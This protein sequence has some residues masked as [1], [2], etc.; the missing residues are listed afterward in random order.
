MYDQYGKEQANAILGTVMTKIF[1]PGLD[2]VTAEY[3]SKQLGDTTIFS[4]TYQDFPGKKNDNIRYAEQKRALMHAGEVRQIGA[5]Q[6]LLIINDTA[7]PIKAAYPP[8]AVLKQKFISPSYGTPK[9]IYLGDIDAG[10]KFDDNGDAD[11]S[12]QNSPSTIKENSIPNRTNLD[13]KINER[14][15]EEVI[16]EIFNEN[17][18]LTETEQTNME[19]Q[20]E[21]MTDQ[22]D[23]ASRMRMAEIEET[24][25]QSE[26]SDL[27]LTI[28]IETPPESVDESDAL[29]SL[30]DDV[31]SAFRELDARAEIEITRSV[32]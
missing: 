1:L 20:T 7:P 5:H 29:D 6:E 32:F 21:F 11:T 22:E 25:E 24:V 13:E 3:A 19:N 30:S 17:P 27:V 15:V 4:K 18:N 28:E 14:I 10:F 2:D 31:R 23:I 16:D 9:V 12:F 8:I 26:N